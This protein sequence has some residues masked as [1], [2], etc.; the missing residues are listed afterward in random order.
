MKRILT[1]VNASRSQHRSGFIGAAVIISVLA[2]IAAPTLTTAATRYGEDGYGACAYQ[3]GCPEPNISNPSGESSGQNPQ[4]YSPPP[5]PKNPHFEIVPA[6]IKDGDVIT[7]KK[8]TLGVSIH[9]LEEAVSSPYV[10][11]FGWVRFYINDRLIGTDYTPDE[12]GVYSIIWDVLANPGTIIT[13]VAYDQDG[14]AVANKSLSVIL[15]LPE[16]LATVTPAPLGPTEEPGWLASTLRSLPPVV[17][18]TFPYWLFLA[19][20]ILALSYLYQTLREA[21]GTERMR[22][23]LKRQQLIAEEKDNFIALGSHYLHTPLT[24][25]R[26][27]ADTVVAIKE[28]PETVTAPLITALTSLK[29][30]IDD[31]LGKVESNEILKD[32]KQPDPIKLSGSLF[33][34]PTYWLPV[35]V[36]A[37][38]IVVMNTLLSLVGKWDFSVRSLGTQFIIGAIVIGF[39]FIAIRTYRLRK[40]ETE[41]L[42][43][44]IEYEHAIDAAR[45][46]FIDESTTVLRD[47]LAAVGTAKTALPATPTANFVTD[48]YNRFAEILSRFDLL[49]QLRAGADY[50]AIEPISLQETFDTIVAEYQ[51]TILSK[52]LTVHADAHGIQAMGSPALLAYVLRTVIDNAVKFTADGGEITLAANK[53][54]GKVEV[55]VTDNGIGIPADKL[56]ILFKPFSRAG[57][58]LTFDYEGLGFSL[59][60]DR[61]IMDYLNG[62]IAVESQEKQ[63]TLVRVTA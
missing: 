40:V 27:G 59:F 52:N 12:D 39:L 5:A 16:D 23:L 33:S 34:N 37:F 11:D 48:G 14:Q 13:I 54:S 51:P 26:N 62:D 43:Q 38:I 19:L 53:T 31:V 8:V 47:G 55:S 61:I 35:A 30:R 9:A 50:G 49:R 32:I 6:G 60:L 10:G 42:N 29:E 58:A 28:A 17:V 15:D 21:I 7:T 4:T 1:F 20:F 24:V 41:K 2:V 57:S 18:Y 46:G 44:L 45:T 3:T 63:G 56:P 36:V 25:M 22:K